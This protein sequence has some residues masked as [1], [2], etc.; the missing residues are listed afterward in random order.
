L[1]E[2]ASACLLP[3]FA[4][5]EPPDW[6]RRRLADG[7]G[8]VVLFAGN[9]RDPE[10]LAALTA[11]LR[12]ER[13]D[14]VIAID[15]EGGD[16]TRLEAE[17]GSSYPGNRAL[18]VVDDVELT[19][20]VAAAIAGDLRAVG[21]NLD[22]APVADVA[23]N[24]DNPVIGVR[25]FGAE[26]ALVARHVAAFVGG[27]QG[28][29]VAACAKH[30]PGHGATAEDS[31]LE[32]PTLSK[33]RDA[34]L[35]EELV[36]FRAA[37]DAGVRAVMTAHIRV[38]AL[39][40][41]PATLSPEVVTGLLREELRFGGL[42]V[43]DALEMR[44]ISG[45]IGV[46]EGAVLA[47][48]AGADALCLGPD[49]GEEAVEPIVRAVVEAVRTGRL[50][51]ERLA[52]AAD[53]VSQTGRWAAAAPG[54]PADGAAGMEAARRAL[55]CEGEVVLSRPPLVVELR[56]EA[57]IAAGPA[58]HGLGDLVRSA[59]VLRLDEPRDVSVPGDRQLVVV[60]RDAHR[61][62]WERELVE[63]LVA[64]DA[65]AVVVETGLPVWRPSGAAGYVATHGSGRANLEAAAE[66]LRP[67]RETRTCRP[68]GS[69]GRAGE[70][71][72]S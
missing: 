65:D 26:P 56:P 68:V 18:G 14:V 15:E 55:R 58:R 59:H 43:T 57:N 40:D 21:V 67:S 37:I 23:S 46:E 31:H 69:D 11:A 19:G 10:Q 72:T 13:A 2:V 25:S 29:G 20:R 30:F 8:G 4:G 9:V 71:R 64:A 48:A 51:G 12:T 7:L 39:G 70:A 52:E 54:A 35:A 53:R 60:A 44:A 47:L 27:L 32:L 42:V 1:I 22:F 17:R 16:V 63:K 33:G 6:L 34:L 38:P 61:H 3:G 50:S 28:G 62:A 41:A 36:P 66:A 45:T 49:L 24:P 5:L